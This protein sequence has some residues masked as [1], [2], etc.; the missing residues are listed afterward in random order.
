MSILTADSIWLRKRCCHTRIQLDVQVVDNSHLGVAGCHPVGD[1]LCEGLSNNS[2]NHVAYV[3]PR[4][5]SEFP[6]NWKVPWNII[7]LHAVVDDVIQS[8]KFELRHEDNLN[9]IVANRLKTDVKKN[10]TI[11]F[12]YQR[13]YPWDA[14]LWQSRSEGGTGGPPWLGSARSRSWSRTWLRRLKQAFVG[15]LG[16]TPGS[17]S[18]PF[19]KIN[20]NN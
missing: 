8:Q 19:F 6:D 9:Q 5:L 16:S 20:Y 11:P 18:S 15:D 10:R 4:E 14:R 13:Q 12:W 2:M 1:P 3:L 7:V 17:C